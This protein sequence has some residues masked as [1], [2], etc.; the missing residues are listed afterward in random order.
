MN[1]NVTLATRS[2]AA[3]AASI[4]VHG[5]LLVPAAPAPLTLT[6]RR[7]LEATVKARR[8]PVHQCA[9]PPLKPCPAS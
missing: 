9:T 7:P 3:V 5:A 4:L 8:L 6:T 2:F 1:L